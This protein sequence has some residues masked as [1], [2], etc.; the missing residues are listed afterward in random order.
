MQSRNDCTLSYMW[1]K[2]AVSRAGIRIDV[3]KRSNSVKVRTSQNGVERQEI[4]R[5][6][7]QLNTRFSAISFD[8]VSESSN[9][10]AYMIA[11]LRLQNLYSGYTVLLYH[12]W[13]LRL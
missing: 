1:L 7:N 11:H 9:S 2:I 6:P 12:T 3:G 8:I 4:W 5:L 10:S 13:L